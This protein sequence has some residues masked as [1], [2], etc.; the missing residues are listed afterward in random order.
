MNKLQL[1]SINPKN[2]INFH[3]WDVLSQS[4]LNQIINK[5]KNAQLDWGS[6]RLESKLKLFD[7][8]TLGDK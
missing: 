1:Q 8:G 2:N 4:E 3:S 5:A 6:L 7:K